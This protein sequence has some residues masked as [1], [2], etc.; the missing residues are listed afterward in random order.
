[1][2]D[3]NKCVSLHYKRT[4]NIQCA[5]HTSRAVAML[6]LTLLVSYLLIKQLLILSGNVEMNPGPLGQQGEATS[7]S[8]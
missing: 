2:N 6:I 5:R 7:L 4:H 3:L 1:M 8:Y